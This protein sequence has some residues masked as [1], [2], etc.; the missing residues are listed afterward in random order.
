MFKLVFHRFI[1]KAI[2]DCARF[3]P[4]NK[5]SKFNKLGVDGFVSVCSIIEQ[6]DE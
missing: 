6:H 2:V 1:A 5:M 3:M 4:F